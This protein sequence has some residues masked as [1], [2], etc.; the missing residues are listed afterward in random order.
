MESGH[1]HAAWLVDEC[2][3]A[4]AWSDPMVAGAA[5]GRRYHP[6]VTAALWLGE[7]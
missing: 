4:E 6:R 1:G 3:R 5:Q 2:N 7:S